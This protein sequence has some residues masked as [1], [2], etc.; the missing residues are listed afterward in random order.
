MLFVAH[1]L[2]RENQNDG[3]ELNPDKDIKPGDFV[4]VQAAA[5]GREPYWVAKVIKVIHYVL[6]KFD[7]SLPLCHLTT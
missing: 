4:L 1:E 3:S 2:C 6:K 5:G 7:F